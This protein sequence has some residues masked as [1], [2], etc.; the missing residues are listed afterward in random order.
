MAT[1]V[2]NP[3]TVSTVEAQSGTSAAWWTAKLDRMANPNSG[4]VAISKHKVGNNC[5]RPLAS[6]SESSCACTHTHTHTHTHTQTHTYSYTHIH[7]HTHSCTHT[8]S[9]THIFIHI[10][11]YTHTH[12]HTHTHTLLPIQT[13]QHYTVLFLGI[14]SLLCLY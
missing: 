7:A 4:K 10:L 2:C 14:C 12:T 5:A 9:S 1:Y 11:I 8:H 3:C 6:T 13:Y